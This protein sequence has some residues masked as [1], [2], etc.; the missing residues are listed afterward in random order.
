MADIPILGKLVSATEE[1]VLADAN[2]IAV[3]NRRLTEALEDKDDK[4]II[5]TTW[6]V[7]FLPNGIYDLGAQTGEK[8]LAFANGTGA[9]DMIYI[10]FSVLAGITLTLSGSNFIGLEGLTE[11]G[12]GTITEIAGIWN[13][14]AGKW[15]LAW[16]TVGE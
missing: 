1:R 10:S 15:M 11:L 9:N 2:E 3:G 4:M 6:P 7:S 16:R 8:T 13:A 5:Y 12:D 14:A